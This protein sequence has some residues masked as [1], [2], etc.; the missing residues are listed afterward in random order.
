MAV[1]WTKPVQTR[2]GRPIRVLCTDQQGAKYPV[3]GLV[4]RKE[5]K[6]DLEQWT[7]DGSFVADKGGPDE[8][9]AI[10]VPE[11]PEERIAYV[12]F[13]DNGEGMAHDSRA[14]ADV[15]AG[16]ARVACVRIPYRVG[17]YDE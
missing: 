5:G 1:D 13:Y 14:R 15:C 16:S 17:Q 6:E 2:D 10:N 11:P 4:K 8:D 9:D 3:L 7:L 12:N